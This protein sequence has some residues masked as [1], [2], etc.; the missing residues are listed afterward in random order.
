MLQLTFIIDCFLILHCDDQIFKAYSSEYLPTV[1]TD[2]IDKN[3]TSV[4][5]SEYV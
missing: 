3:E 4:W 1:G 2:D 5:K